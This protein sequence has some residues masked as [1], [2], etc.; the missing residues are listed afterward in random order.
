[1]VPFNKI[2]EFKDRNGKYTQNSFGME[3]NTILLADVQLYLICPLVSSQK[4]KLAVR[5]RE[6]KQRNGRRIMD[7][8]YCGGNW[9][10]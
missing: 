1:M 5:A 2:T 6:L 8:D 7:G 4:R 10:A 3:C 9:L